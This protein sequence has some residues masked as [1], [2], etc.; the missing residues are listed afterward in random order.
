MARPTWKGSISFGL[1]NVPVQLYTAVRSQDIRFRQLHGKTHA[2]VKQQRIDVE[3]GEEVDYDDLVKGYETEDGRYVIV[4]PDELRQLDPKASELIDIHDFVELAD[5]DP[6]YYERPY[7]L[8]P[9]GKAAA[10]P[11]RLLADA[12]TRE[13]KVAIASFVM[14]NKEY[15][16]A[17]RAH[18]GLL[19]LSTMHHAD[20]V[21]DPEDLDIEG[22][23]GDVEVR[24]R[25]VEMAQR[26]IDSLV[27]DFEPAAYEDS[28]RQRLMEFLE[29]KAEGQDVELPE[30]EP[31]RG[32]VIDLT[33]AL[34][35]SLE[36]AGRAGKGS[37]RRREPDEGDASTSTGTNGGDGKR[38]GRRAEEKGSAGRSAGDAY[39]DLTRDELYQLAQERDLPGRSSMS[40][41]D[42]VAAL[43]STDAEAG[44]A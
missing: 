40:K 35:Q 39:E 10:K 12:M 9:N 23:I 16:A 19:I 30:V 29:A 36:R 32:G 25:E 26:L 5:I 4:D 8:A 6:L 27:T 20:E 18:D 28:Y 21:V 43:R 11:Y 44:A 7:Y 14:R 15:L 41:R 13:G 22:L 1:V 31:D 17:I 3:T 2:R 38:R 37:G 42:L 24:E 34:E 33:A